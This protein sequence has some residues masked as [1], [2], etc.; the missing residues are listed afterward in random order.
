MKFTLQEFILKNWIIFTLQ[1]FI[2]KN[3]IIFTLQ[4][5]ILKNWIIF[6][7]QEF[8]LK[9]WII[10]TLQEFILKNWNYSYITSFFILKNKEKIVYEILFEEIKKNSSKYYNILNLQKKFHCDFEIGI[11]NASKNF[12]PNIN[13]KYCAFHYKSELEKN[14]KKKMF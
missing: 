3:W 2:L 4:G 1:E 14:K 11:F 6:T 7:L 8:I 10:F 13:I 9:N 12:F 5:F